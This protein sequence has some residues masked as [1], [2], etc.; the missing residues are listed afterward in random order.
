MPRRTC[1]LTASVLLLSMM[2]AGAQDSAKN[3]V[4]RNNAEIRSMRS[5]AAKDPDYI[6]GP[7]DV[8]D[9]NVWREPDL[10]RS[11]P[12]RPDGKISLPL[13]NDVQAAGLT[14][15]EL[16][17][18]IA[19]KFEQ[20][21]MSP[22]VTVIVSQTNSQ[23]VYILGEIARTGAYTLLPGM[24]ILQAI[25]N[26]GGPSPFAHAKNIYVLREENGKQL[27]YFFNYKDVVAG[28]RMEQNIALKPSD[29]IVVP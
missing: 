25:S 29:T 13:I 5:P 11:V 8:L 19:K 24:T 4:A 23:R 1:I 17:T 16:A 3:Q 9:I 26:A 6:V 22:Q 14:P 12:V 10:T 2:P 18:E 7:Q 15:T 27:K 20:F 28:K 21:V